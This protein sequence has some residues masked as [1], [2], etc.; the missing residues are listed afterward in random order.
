[1][2]LKILNIK[3]IIYKGEIYNLK[4]PGIYGYFQIL[5]NHDFFISILDKGILTFTD[6]KINK[7]ITINISIGILKVINNFI[8]I[9]L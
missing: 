6:K 1:M 2:K 4:A 3:N 7:K 9:L 5:K 8:I